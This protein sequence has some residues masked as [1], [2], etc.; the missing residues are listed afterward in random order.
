[1]TLRQAYEAYDMPF[2]HLKFH[3]YL[4]EDSDPMVDIFINGI[5]VY[6]TYIFDHYDTVNKPSIHIHT[7][8]MH[9][10]NYGVD[11]DGNPAPSYKGWFTYPR[12]IK[13]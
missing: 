8:P 6:Q 3:V 2:W 12:L 10:I 1:M 5:M 11:S 9:L 7:L 13:L 4:D